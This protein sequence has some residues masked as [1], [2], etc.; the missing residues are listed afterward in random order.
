MPGP[1]GQSQLKLE[2]TR[3]LSMIVPSEV[4]QQKE[5][6]KYSRL[7]SNIKSIGGF[8]NFNHCRL[9]RSHGRTAEM[10]RVSSG[11]KGT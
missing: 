9:A 2:I 1:E 6:D 11:K 3:Q 5:L 10:T 4:Q 8:L 7:L